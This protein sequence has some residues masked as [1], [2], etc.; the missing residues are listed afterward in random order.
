[1]KVI[2]SLFRYELYGYALTA[3]GFLVL[4]TGCAN[5]PSS[6]A[7]VYDN[8]I[9]RNAAGSYAYLGR[10]YLLR[11]TLDLAEAR[12]LYAIH[13][14]PDFPAAH[15]DLAVVYTKM[16]KFDAADEE[17]RIALKLVPTD[18]AILYNY[19]TLLYN[20]GRYVDAELQLQALIA[21]PK[22][23]NRAQAYEAL[24]LIALKTNDSIKAEGYF[25]QALSIASGL[26]R[27]LLELTQISINADRLSL[28]RNYLQRYQEIAHDTP[29]GLWLGI[30][31]GRAQGDE[32]MVRDY[33]QRLR[34]KFPD[35][36]QARQ[37]Y[38][39]IRS[40]SPKKFF[41]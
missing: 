26:P 22:A 19:A 35:S 33:G 18:E 10:Q 9:P 12:L 4:L 31:L 7:N 2:R 30:L 28:A 32:Q 24:G 15:H 23:E 13:L 41:P 8:E 25:G 17:Y 11:D 37:F 1:M 39:E 36:P 14:N 21:N 5:H 34:V 16:G 3:V 27:T 6:V 20:Q 38:T 40:H 29:E